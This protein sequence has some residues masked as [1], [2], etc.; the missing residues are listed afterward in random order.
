MTFLR[1]VLIYTIAYISFSSTS[2]EA[3][4]PLILNNKEEK[5]SII[6]CNIV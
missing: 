2:Y 1:H 5:K 6:A 3:Y 4:K